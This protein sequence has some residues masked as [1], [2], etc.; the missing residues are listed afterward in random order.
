MDVY[1][2]DVATT[3]NIPIKTKFKTV[4]IVLSENTNYN[5]DIDQEWNFSSLIY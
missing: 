5:K 3:S 1:I 2:N 4:E